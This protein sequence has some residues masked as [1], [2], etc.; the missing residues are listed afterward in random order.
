MFF[1][2][3]DSH[4]WLSTWVVLYAF[5]VLVKASSCKYEILGTTKNIKKYLRLRISHLIEGNCA[6]VVWR[7]KFICENNLNIQKWEISTESL[8][9]RWI[10]NCCLQSYGG[11]FARWPSCNIPRCI[12]T[13]WHQPDRF[14]SD[15]TTWSFIAILCWKSKRSRNSGIVTILALYL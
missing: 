7:G 11:Y 3:Y 13:F 10:N 8:R 5:F 6:A 14:H 9:E 12:S 1:S 4:A 15:K 2:F